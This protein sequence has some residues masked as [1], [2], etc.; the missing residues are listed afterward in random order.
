M[1]RGNPIGRDSQRAGV[2]G[3]ARR[4]DQDAQ[5]GG[6]A[7]HR[8]VVAGKLQRSARIVLDGQA[9]LRL[10]PAMQ[11]VATP[12]RGLEAGG[13]VLA[14]RG[15]GRVRFRYALFG[16]RQAEQ[17]RVVPD[18]VAQQRNYVARAIAIDQELGVD[19]LEVGV[20]RIERERVA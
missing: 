9:K 5:V 4:F 17:Q 10:F 7:L 13:Q 1:H 18:V 14:M 8:P 16:L 2:A 20:T 6:L 11:A 15:E 19:T 3:R 12:A